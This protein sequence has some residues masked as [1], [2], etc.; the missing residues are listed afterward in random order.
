MGNSTL[1][2]LDRKLSRLEEIRRLKLKKMHAALGLD[3]AREALTDPECRALYD[4]RAELHYQFRVPIVL[5]KLEGEALTGNIRAIE[6]YL[7]LFWLPYQRVMGVEATA[8]GRSEVGELLRKILRQAPAAA[9]V[10]LVREVME[11]SGP[12]APDA[13]A[14]RAIS[15]DTERVQ[16]VEG[17]VVSDP[18]VR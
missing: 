3:Y 9:K 13:S 14:E 17:T 10:R 11:V 16:V 6:L 18:D 4:Q 1:A 5:D 15:T 2:L 12:A 8:S 7:R